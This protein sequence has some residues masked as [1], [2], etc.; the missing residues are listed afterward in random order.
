MRGARGVKIGHGA[1]CAMSVPAGEKRPE[2]STVENRRVVE[3]L[4]HMA[5]RSVEQLAALAAGRCE[6]VGPPAGS[7]CRS[8]SDGPLPLG[9]SRRS[10][11]AGA[12]RWDR[13]PVRA[14]ARLVMARFR[15]AL[16]GAR[17]R[18]ASRAS[19][20]Y[21]SG[22][23][24][25]P[26]ATGSPPTRRSCV[27]GSSLRRR[28]CDELSKLFENSRRSVC[29]FHPRADRNVRLA[30][31]LG[32]TR[33]STLRLDVEGRGERSVFSFGYSSFSPWSLVLGPWSFPRSGFGRCVERSPLTPS[34]FPT[35]GRG[36]LLLSALRIGHVTVLREGPGSFPWWGEHL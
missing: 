19:R 17:R 25:R 30:I 26:D 28:S 35:S 7:S 4:A 22:R 11:P 29:R 16:V 14:A 15:W 10:P 24:N 12:R 2:G 27:L 13:R 6:A 23:S 32:Q 20:G 33:M 3:Q 36:E 31:R 21:S 9:A 5:G 8:V 1:N 34:R 18:P